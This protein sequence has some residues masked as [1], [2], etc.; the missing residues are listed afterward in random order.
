MLYHGKKTWQGA[1]AS[2]I[3]PKRA[4]NA[5]RYF[6]VLNCASENGFVGD[7]RPGMGL[8]DAEVGY[9]NLWP[10]KEHDLPGWP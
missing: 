1:R 2:W 5:G 7:V 10:A 9:G 4:G 6:S 3:E 8:G